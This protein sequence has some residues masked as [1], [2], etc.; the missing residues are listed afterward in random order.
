VGGASLGSLEIAFEPGQVK[1]GDYR[2]SVGSA[3]SATLVLQTILPALALAGGPSTVAL[4]GGTHNPFAPP[5]DFLAGAFLPVFSRMGPEITSLL[6]R[7]GF[8]PAGG[9][10]FKVAIDPVEKFS[11]VELFVRGPVGK[12]RARAIV[13]N[14]PAAIARREL[15]VL[16]VRLDLT[17]DECSE[18]RVSS[19]GPGNVVLVEIGSE[20]VTEIFTGY[21]QKGVPAETVAE[22]AADEAI[23]YL[24]SGVPVGPYLADQLLVP[25]AIAG[26]GGF[27]TVEPSSH[28]I[29][30]IEAI[31]RFLDVEI[32]ILERARDV[33]EIRF[34]S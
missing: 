23:R 11:P 9:G 29:T 12:R 18:E 31:G 13:A 26:G 10:S 34:G 19:P 33:C 2:F 8:Y 20:H 16:A 22:R 1:P 6:V 24:A 17:G 15:A 28:A 5:W 30:N 25:A 4:E 7:H 14:L 21:G 3:G 32:R 27:L